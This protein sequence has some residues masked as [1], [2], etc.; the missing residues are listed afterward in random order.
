[1]LA[2]AAHPLI[3]LIDFGSAC[4]ENHT[5]FSYIQSRFYRAPDGDLY[6]QGGTLLVKKGGTVV[7]ADRARALGDHAPL[8]DVVDVA[9]A[10]RAKG[11]PIA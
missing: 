2:S 1:M 9:L 10:L 8:V 5:S 4:Y 3:K 6:Q 11:A 7:F